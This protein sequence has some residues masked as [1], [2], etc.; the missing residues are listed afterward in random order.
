MKIKALLL[1]MFCGI[2]LS[3]SAGD[4]DLLMEM[5]NDRLAVRQKPGTE[6][7][8]R[9]YLDSMEFTIVFLHIMKFN[10]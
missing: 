2:A 5:V 6:K 9:E 3:L 10:H 1:L 8:L 4:F 7:L